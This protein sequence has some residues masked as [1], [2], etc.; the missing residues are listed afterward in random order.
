MAEAEAEA[1]DIC[2][3]CGEPGADKMAH[4]C[5]WPGETLPTGPYVHSDCEREECERAFHAF[6]SRVGDEGVRR[7]LGI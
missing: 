4:P 7:F 3:L 1:E 6:S 2:G 5:H